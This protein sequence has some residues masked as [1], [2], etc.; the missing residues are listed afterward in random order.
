[1]WLGGTKAKRMN[2]SAQARNATHMTSSLALTD[3][4]IARLAPSVFAMT[5][6]ESRSARYAHIPTVDVLTGLRK[7]GFVP[8]MAQQ[9]KCRV[10]GKSD[11]TKHMIR[12]RHVDS[13]ARANE[14][15]ADVNEVIVLN[16]H[17]GTSAYKMMA[18]CFRFVCANGM[19]VGNIID[20][21][22]VKHTGTVVQ[23]VIEGA[24]RILDGFNAVDAA[25]DGMKSL[26]L[27]SGEQNVFAQAAL[28]LRYPEAETVEAA[29]IAI[30]D[31][32]RARRIEDQ[33]NS[34]WT[35]FQRAQETLVNGGVRTRRN[36]RRATTRAI[37]GIDG[38]VALNRGLWILAEGMKALRIAA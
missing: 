30:A 33:D 35:T 38:N 37:T 12:L 23:D 16:S 32:L 3:A 28:A 8:F 10:E 26:Q 14:V 1:M 7:E 25:K 34:L 29:P 31:V 19:V 6:H 13:M 2:F 21:I 27:T 20:D 36:G 17:D 5:A 24:Y 11:F 18:G 4:D 9:G 15:G 22:H